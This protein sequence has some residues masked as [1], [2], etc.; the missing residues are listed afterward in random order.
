MLNR[1]LADHNRNSDGQKYHD[2]FQQQ[3]MGDVHKGGSASDRARQQ[4]VSRLP[5]LGGTGAVVGVETD[6]SMHLL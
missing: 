6:R 2:L 4:I 3:E 1:A 5:V